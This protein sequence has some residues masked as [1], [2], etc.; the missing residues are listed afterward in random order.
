MTLTASAHCIR[1][2]WTA[3]AGDLP[4]ADRAAETHTRKTGHPTAIV[5][6]PAD[7][8]VRPSHRSPHGDPPSR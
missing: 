6:Q 1:C 3:G 7:V 2:D 4:A 5:A 8:T